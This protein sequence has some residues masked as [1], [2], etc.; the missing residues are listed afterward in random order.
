[1]VKNKTPKT[2]SFILKIILFA[3]LLIFSAAMAN[4]FVLIALTFFIFYRAYQKI[5]N[6]EQVNGMII[7]VIAIFGL[8]FNGIIVLKMRRT[9]EKDINIKSVFWH[10]MEDVLGWAGV[11]VAG[12]V[13]IFTG[14]YIIDPII[15]IL[16]GF[17]VIYGAFDVVKETLDI[18]MLA[19]P[20]GVNIDDIIKGIKRVPEVKGVH[21]LHVWTVGSNHHAL[22]GH[23]LVK[24]TKI[25]KTYPILCKVNKMLEKKFNIK[26]TTIEFEC[27]NCKRICY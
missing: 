8:V 20:E 10:L 6:P 21:D 13:I 15:S 24:D 4:A 9:K 19:V 11:L 26:H 1:M 12:I 16:I 18:F 3:T 2:D 25:S 14:W 7:F 23:L 17:I 5:L 27:V 22:S